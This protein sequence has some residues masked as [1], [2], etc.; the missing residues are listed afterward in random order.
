MSCICRNKFLAQILGEAENFETY[1][2]EAKG[3]ICFPRSD[4][5]AQLHIWKKLEISLNPLAT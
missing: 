2:H 3:K 1:K 4:S 5:V